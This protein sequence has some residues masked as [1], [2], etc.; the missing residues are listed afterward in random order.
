M[1]IDQFDSQ[2]LKRVESYNFIGLCS[3]YNLD[4]S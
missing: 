2:D 4:S 1:R 3:S